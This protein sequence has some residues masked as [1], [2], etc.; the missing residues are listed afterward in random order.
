MKLWVS[1][2]RGETK[3]S[4][5]LSIGTSNCS[6]TIPTKRRWHI[7]L[8]GGRLIGKRVKQCGILEESHFRNTPTPLFGTGFH[9]AASYF[10]RVNVWIH[11]RDP[12][13]S[14]HSFFF[15]A[16]LRSKKSSPWSFHHTYDREDSS[17]LRT[18]FDHLS[19][20]W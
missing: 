1:S 13:C 5:A 6:V 9:L 18:P 10:G 3:H 12:F 7:K 17:T 16:C 4:K 19:T 2:R 8:S 20:R 14:N 15:T 11:R